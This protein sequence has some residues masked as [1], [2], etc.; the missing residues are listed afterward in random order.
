MLLFLATSFIFPTGDEASAF[1]GFPPLLS[2][3]TILAQD[4]PPWHRLLTGGPGEGP[5]Y[6]ALDSM[7]GNVLFGYLSSGRCN[8]IPSTGWLK[9]WRLASPRSRCQLIQFLVRSLFLACSQLPPFYVLTWQRA[10]KLWSLPLL[11][12]NSNLILQAPHSWLSKFNTSQ[13]PH[14][15]ILSC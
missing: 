7:E 5:G 10:S 13:S 2:L 3:S 15:Q 6:Q 4:F 1:A 11:N 12:K 14:L 8:R 9:F